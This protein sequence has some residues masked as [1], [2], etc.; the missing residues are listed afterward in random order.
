M[1]VALNRLMLLFLLGVSVFPDVVQ[2]VTGTRVEGRRTVEHKGGVLVGGLFELGFGDSCQKRVD[3]LKAYVCQDDS[4][5]LKIDKFSLQEHIDIKGGRDTSDIISGIGKEVVDGQGHLT[6]G[7]ANSVEHKNRL[8]TKSDGYSLQKRTNV[9]EHE[10]KFLWDQANAILARISALI[11]EETNSTT[12]TCPSPS[13]LPPPLPC[14]PNSVPV[15]TNP[16]ISVIPI[17]PRPPEPA[18]VSETLPRLGP[19]PIQTGVPYHSTFPNPFHPLPSSSSNGRLCT[20][21]MVL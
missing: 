14:T 7:A 17:A 4:A 10:L 20:G 3:V 19:G 5:N 2:F 18:N 13:P 6:S 9:P 15:K 11:G 16:P 21:S 12:C 1:T 8:V